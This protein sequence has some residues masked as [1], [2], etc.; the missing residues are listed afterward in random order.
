MNQEEKDRLAEKSYRELVD[1]VFV[2]DYKILGS[3]DGD[4]FLYFQ[5]SKINPNGGSYISCAL[6]NLKVDTR[7]YRGTNVELIATATNFKKTS[8]KFNAETEYKQIY[9]VDRLFESNFLDLSEVEKIPELQDTY[10]EDEGFSY[11]N[12]KGYRYRLDLDMTVIEVSEDHF[13]RWGPKIVKKAYFPVKYSD[14]TS[15]DTVD[16]FDDLFKSL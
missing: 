9:I 14:Y 3:G 10:G 1:R 2:K 15:P 4:K 16:T 13:N 6:F 5:P 8:F 12:V 11:L 7:V